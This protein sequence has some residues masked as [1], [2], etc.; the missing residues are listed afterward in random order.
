MRNEQDNCDN[1]E[2]TEYGVEHVRHD[3]LFKLVEKFLQL[4]YSEQ[5][6]ESQEPNYLEQP[7]QLGS[8]VQH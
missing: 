7:Q 5:S 8:P 1:F 4:E 2:E 3:D 6:Q